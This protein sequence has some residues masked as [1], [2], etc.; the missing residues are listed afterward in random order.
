MTITELTLTQA[1]DWHVHLRDGEILTAVVPDTARRFARA[2]VMPNLNPPIYTV[3][4]ARSYRERIFAAIPKNISFEPLMTLYLTDHTSPDEIQ[5]AKQSGIVYGVGEVFLAGATTNSDFGVSD[6]KKCKDVLKMME[7]VDLPLLVHGEEIDPEIDVFDREQV[8]I[9]KHLIPIVEQYP[10]LRIIL[11]H[12][13]TSSAVEF[14]TTSPGNVAATITA[15]HLLLNRN[16]MF[17]GG[18]H[19]HAYC[20]PILKRE[21]HR[22]ALVAAATSG[23]PKFFLGT[24]SAPHV[25]NTKEAFCGCAGIYTAHAGI[26]LYAEVFDQAGALDKLEGFASIHGPAFYDL[27]RNPG[28]TRLIKKS[29]NVPQEISF[30][31]QAGVPM[32]SGE[33]ISWQLAD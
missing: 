2:M 1:D 6:F 27:P 8:F 18:L 15:H 11:E 19:P 24:D 4:D 28:N 9:E 3:D 33:E 31:K 10:R 14:V 29:W 22:Q 20:L 5:R 17:Q 26:E 7:E 16:A 12:I 13:T 32:R 23:N 30:G 21:K 25:R